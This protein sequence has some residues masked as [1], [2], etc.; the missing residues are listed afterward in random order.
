MNRN[1]I[2]WL[3]S[4]S[5]S[6]KAVILPQSHNKGLKRSLKPSNTQ[7]KQTKQARKCEISGSEEG[8]RKKRHQSKMRENRRHS[9]KIVRKSTSAIISKIGNIENYGRRKIPGK[10]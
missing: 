6:R 10:K 8:A 2:K 9:R 3:E 1:C 4:A 5:N 7:E